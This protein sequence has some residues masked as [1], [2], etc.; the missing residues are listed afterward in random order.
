[1]NAAVYYGCALLIIITLT[2]MLALGENEWAA[3][4]AGGT[5]IGVVIGRWLAN[6]RR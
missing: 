5:I 1:M 3:V 4:T 6:A 2:V